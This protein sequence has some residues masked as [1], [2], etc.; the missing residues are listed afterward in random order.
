MIESI[1]G[2]NLFDVCFEFLLQP[3]SHLLRWSG[4]NFGSTASSLVAWL[5]VLA[6][7]IGSLW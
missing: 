1:F 4:Q 5:D 6:S 2:K 3:M 7:L